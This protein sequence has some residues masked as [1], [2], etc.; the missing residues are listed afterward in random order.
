MMGRVK[1]AE[2]DRLIWIVRERGA[3]LGQLTAREAL[4]ANRERGRVFV[5][6][7][8]MPQ[9]QRTAGVVVLCLG[10]KIL[11]PTVLFKIER[12][13]CQDLLPLV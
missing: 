6:D 13:E 4:D 2:E 9:S 7:L 5:D 12:G 11:L 8:I 3:A 10:C 1:I